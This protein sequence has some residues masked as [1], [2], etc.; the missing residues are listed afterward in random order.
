MPYQ[1]LLVPSDGSQLS[2]KAL[3]QAIALA[4]SLG[5]KLTVL[6]VQPP[7]PVPLIG[8][9]DMLDPA[10]VASLSATAAQEGERILREAKEASQREELPI[11]CE[12]VRH[13]LIG[14]AIVEA[15]NR[16]GCD[17]I[18]MAS[19]GRKGLTRLLLGSETQR[20]LL[21]ASVPVLVVR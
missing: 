7:L 9:G 10:T 17:L 18:V 15:A 13:D 3:A 20:V 4:K 11:D 16:H 2:A 19:H 8:M 5:A 21:H 6:H 12:L 14:R 1:H